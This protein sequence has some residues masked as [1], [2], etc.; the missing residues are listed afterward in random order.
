MFTTVIT[1]V[2]GALCVAGIFAAIKSRWL[3]VI[4]PKLYLNTPISDGQIISFNIFNAGLLAEEDVAITFRQACKFELIGTSK[5]SLV[6]NGQTLSIPKLSRLESITVILLIEGKAFD[7]IDIESIESKLTVGKTVE[8]KEKAT[9]FWQNIIAYPLITMFL[10]V[11]FAFG[12]SVGAEMKVSMFSYISEK[13]E[14]LE[15][16]KQLAGFK[17][18]L[19]EE[20]ADKVF[21][22]AIVRSKLS[23][24]PV[25]V[26]R[27][28]E[29][30][31]IINK[32]SNNTNEPIFIEGY[33]ESS[34]GDRGSLDFWAGRVEKFA[35]APNES[36]SVKQKAFLPES[37][38]VKIIVNRFTFENM[39]GDSISVS[40]TMEFK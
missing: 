28:G 12:T 11:P 8:S 2:I 29:I 27:R 10:L 23:I 39:K 9:A 5:S 38:S 36:K 19:R 20:R 31:T 16:S 3:Y 24:E 4:A 30:L 22:N 37:I 40:Q 14:F 15:N 35:L 21:K 1:S 7:P 25:E 18:H 32:L 33:L 34:A 13:V 26:I 6:V 17:T